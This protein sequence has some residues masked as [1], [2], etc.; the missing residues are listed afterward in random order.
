MGGWTLLLWPLAGW[1]CG[2]S[3][4]TDVFVAAD[5][6]PMFLFCGLAGPTT[7]LVR[8][9]CYL[10]DRSSVRQRQATPSSQTTTGTSRLNFSFELQRRGRLVGP[11][12]TPNRPSRLR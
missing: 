10:L 9:L 8:P 11:S 2:F 6:P 7:L 3:V 5:L 12:L 4:W 1:A